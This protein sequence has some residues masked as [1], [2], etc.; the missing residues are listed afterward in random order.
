MYI[1]GYDTWAFAVSLCRKNE[2]DSQLREGTRVMARFKAGR[3]WFP[4]VVWQVSL[5]WLRAFVLC[6]TP[7][8]RHEPLASVCCVNISFTTVA[9]CGRTVSFAFRAPFALLQLSR[10]GYTIHYDD[11][12][13]E[14][15]VQL[16]CLQPLQVSNFAT[17]PLLLV[18]FIPRVRP[19]LVRHYKINSYMTNC[20]Q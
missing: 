1:P 7:P 3:L 8:R 11:G 13:K 12:D 10:G 6:P 18:M 4:G 19:M 20:N 15:N 14:E 16:S 17:Q 9:P 5:Y 2:V